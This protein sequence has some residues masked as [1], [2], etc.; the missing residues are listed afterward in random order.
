MAGLFDNKIEIA[1]I[2]IWTAKLGAAIRSRLRGD[3]FSPTVIDV[4]VIDE[5]AD[6]NADKTLELNLTPL[7]KPLEKILDHEQS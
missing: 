7:D 6:E 3:I 1:S 2:P 4:I 5:K